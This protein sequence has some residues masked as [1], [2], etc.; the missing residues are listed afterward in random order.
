M[1]M[2]QNCSIGNPFSGQGSIHLRVRLKPSSEIIGSEM[3]TAVTFVVS[4]LNSESRSTIDDGSN[5]DQVVIS[6][7]A[8]ANIS[9]ENG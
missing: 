3:D 2:S 5:V 8:R 6:F 9:I 1:G 7:E 4:S